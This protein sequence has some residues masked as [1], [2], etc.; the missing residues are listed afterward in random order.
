MWKIGR[1][2]FGALCVLI[3]FA[4]VGKLTFW[5]YFDYKID[6]LPGVTALK[7]HKFALTTVV[8]DDAGRVIDKF[9]L[10]DR[11]FM[12][13]DQIPEN[14][15][16]AIVAAEDKNFWRNR[17]IS[18]IDV[19]GIIRA[20]R[21][22]FAVSARESIDQKKPVKKLVAG[23]STITQQVAKLVWLSQEKTASRKFKEM[24]IAYQ[25]EKRLSKEL[26]FETYVNLVYMGHNRY[27]IVAGSQFYFGKAPSALTV[28]EAAVL[29]GIIKWPY[30]FSPLNNL[31]VA[32]DRRNTI[33]ERMERNGFISTAELRELRSTKLVLAPY[34]QDILAPYFSSYFMEEL[35]RLGYKS[36]VT[37]GLSVYSTI[38]SDIQR[39]AN[40]ALAKG[41]AAYDERHKNRLVLYNIFSDYDLDSFDSFR[42]DNW[43]SEIGIGSVIDGLVTEVNSERVLVKIANDKAVISASSF[44]KIREAGDL[45]KLFKEGDVVILKITGVD[46]EN[47]FTVEILQ[48]RIEGAVVVVDVGTGAVKAMV[49]GRDFSVSKYNRAMQ[50]ERQA[51][52]TFKPFVYGAYFEKFP[53]RDLESKV[54]DAPICFKTGNPRKPK[55]CPKNYDEKSLPPF[56]GSIPVRI[57]IARSRN[58]A[59]VRTAYATDIN[60]VVDLAYALGITS[61]LPRYLPTAIGAADVKVIDMATAFAAFFRQGQ[62]RPYWFIER[63]VDKNNEN[64]RF[65]PAEIKQAISKESADKVLEAMR[66]VV[67]AGTGRSALRELPFAVAGKTGTTN[68]FTDAWFVGGTPRYV[69]AVWVGF[70]RKAVSLVSRGAP[71]KETGGFTALPIFIEIMKEIYKDRNFDEFPEEIELRIKGEPIPEKEETKNPD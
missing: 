51:G 36:V 66:W 54:L 3:I 57:A 39:I 14:V 69:I 23:G 7:S 48:P 65:E 43:N 21:D 32:R 38:N 67:L 45:T 20:F 49:G 29:A 27:G 60:N 5:Y 22:D 12:P 34:R 47:N 62:V 24:R 71:H 52:S 19:V 42:A 33:L 11:A 9:A 37:S 4:S 8:Y 26:I 50:A 68:N 41:L 25:M 31:E 35:H 59:A 70:D 2:L 1:F 53:D 13:F 30:K 16:N 44:A 55:W 61:E 28:E 10:E 46:A 18:G 64:K 17:L 40:Q 56:M 6:D 58:V 15:N 63:V